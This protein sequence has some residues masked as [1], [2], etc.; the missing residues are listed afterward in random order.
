MIANVQPYIFGKN[1]IALFHLH[2]LKRKT[3]IGD[4]PVIRFAIRKRTVLHA[5]MC[6]GKPLQETALEPRTRLFQKN[7]SIHDENGLRIH[8][9]GQ[10]FRPH[11]M[12][13]V[14]EVNT[15]RSR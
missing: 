10:L 9:D 7:L 6:F 12:H 13:L 11:V 15:T 1:A 8:V 14:L 4:L 5:I 2:V 3:P